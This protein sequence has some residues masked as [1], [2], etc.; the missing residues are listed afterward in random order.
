[1]MCPPVEPDQAADTGSATHV[2]V[3]QQDGEQK[4]KRTA[5]CSCNVGETR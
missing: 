1:M 2:N 4:R 3:P 5:Q